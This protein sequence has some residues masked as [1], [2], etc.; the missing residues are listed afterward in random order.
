M[1][2]VHCLSRWGLIVLGFAIALAAV[3]ATG[4][5]PTVKPPNYDAYVWPPPPDAPRIKLEDIVYGRSDVMAKTG[6][7]QRALLGA[8]PHGPYDWFKKPFAVDFDRAGRLLV[9][10][11]ALGALFR[12]DR[13]TRRA[14][15]FGTKGAVTLKSP[16]G[17][18][19]GPDGVVYVADVGT[20]RVV[21]FD[22]DGG[23]RAVY[24]KEGEL[25][26]PTDALVSPD[27]STLF[28]ADSKAHQIVTF[29]LGTGARTGAFGRQGSGDGEFSFPSAL[30]LGPAGNLLVVD[31]M[32]ARVQVLSLDG[33][34]VDE[35]GA[36]GVGFANFVR[37][38]DV[39]CDEVGFV[40][41]TDAAFNNVQI[42]SDDY[43]LLTSVGSGGQQPGQF[44]VASGVA[45]RGER[46]AVA[47]QLGRRV[48]VFRYV[49]PKG[50]P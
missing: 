9:T 13:A 6:G 48:Q 30:A 5:A 29:D 4:C 37:P 49:A 28:V 40:Y 42:F 41:V 43:Q 27:N 16:L 36:L 22:E 8:S 35:F 50:A 2:K 31:Q 25:Q 3:N 47:D 32:N 33:R 21:A 11:Q 1:Y 12:L 46:V 14:D 34:Y 10:D 7:L 23:V 19:V 26:N 44:Q 24:G 18:G 45:V 39:A 20:R 17:I 15:V 38:K